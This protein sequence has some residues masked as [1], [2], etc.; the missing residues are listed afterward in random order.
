MFRLYGIVLTQPMM[1]VTELAALGS[2]R[3][4]LRKQCG[5][6]MITDLWDYALQVATGMEYLEKKRCIHRDLACRNIL[7]TTPHQV[8]FLFIIIYYYSL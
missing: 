4:Y 2:L 5:H 7:L 1:M 8:L 3:D 6:I